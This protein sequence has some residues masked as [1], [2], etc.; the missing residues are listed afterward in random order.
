MENNEGK[1]PEIPNTSPFSEEELKN[2]GLSDDEIQSIF[3]ADA[4]SETI[5]TQYPQEPENVEE[6]FNKVPDT[7][8]LDDD[9]AEFINLFNNPKN[10]DYLQQLIALFEIDVKLEEQPKIESFSSVEDIQ[11]AKSEEEWKEI[12]KCIEKNADS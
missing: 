6:L 12:L 8:D 11:K 5:L 10:K 3:T 1:L 9:L 4:V 7:G 2:L